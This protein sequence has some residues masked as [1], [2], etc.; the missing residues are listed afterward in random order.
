MLTD[1]LL[2][3]LPASLGNLRQLLNLNVD[4]NQIQ[5]LPSTI[6][7]CT[8]LGLLSVR[9]NLLTEVTYFDIRLL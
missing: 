6:G 5:Q 1:N 3:E 8:S 7:S 4:K 9:D 2:Q